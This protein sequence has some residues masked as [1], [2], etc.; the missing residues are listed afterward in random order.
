[1][2]CY[3]DEVLSV[4]EYIQKLFGR[5]PD[6]FDGSDDLQQ[7]WA[8]PDTRQQ[9]LDTLEEAGF[10]EEKL[11]LLKR[12]LDMDNCDLLDVLEYIA[13]DS[14]PM[15]RAQR[16]ELVEQ[17]YLDSLNAEQKAFDQYILGFYA[18][19]GFTE[20]GKDKLNVFI[21]YKYG[22]I[23]DAQEKLQM[24]PSSIREHYY[25]LQRWLYCA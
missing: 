5:L 25:Q 16:V 1:M 9:L 2:I 11:N 6:F 18:Q 10:A 21:K 24:N 12:M 13:Y 22:T 15:E 17:K 8:N 4:S 19:N 7:K 20:L 23:S 3:G 14:T